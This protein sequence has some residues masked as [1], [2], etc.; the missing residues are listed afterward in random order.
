M[1]LCWCCCKMSVKPMAYTGSCLIALPCCIYGSK[2]LGLVELPLQSSNGKLLGIY[3]IETCNA[4]FLRCNW[5]FNWG[6]WYNII[7]N[8][9]YFD[10]QLWW[11]LRQSFWTNSGSKSFHIFKTLVLFSV[12]RKRDKFFVLTGMTFFQVQE[13]HNASKMAE[14]CCA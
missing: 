13:E 12:L 5:Q 9:M 10:Y 1:W 11:A 8:L 3:G 2:F 6:P 4:C 14:H 7:C